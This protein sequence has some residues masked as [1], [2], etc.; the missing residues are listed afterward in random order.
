MSEGVENG[1][2]DIDFFGDR[3]EDGEFGSDRVPFFGFEDWV[4]SGPISMFTRLGV[5]GLEMARVMADAVSRGKVR[6]DGGKGGWGVIGVSIPVVVILGGIPRDVGASSKAIVIG[7]VV[8]G[9]G[10]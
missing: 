7:G 1:I 6:W 3:G 4:V 2:F 9:Q 8:H 10:A 5:T